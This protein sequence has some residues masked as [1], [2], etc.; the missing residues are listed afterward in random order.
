[1]THALV[2]VFKSSPEMVRNKTESSVKRFNGPWVGTAGPEKLELFQ[3]TTSAGYINAAENGTTSKIDKILVI[4]A[5]NNAQFGTPPLE[6][7]LRAVT[8][9]VHRSPGLRKR[10]DAG[11]PAGLDS[12]A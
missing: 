10:V 9:S 7:L 4:V 6:A 8:R 11:A 3:T 2:D 12:L 5:Q 1:L